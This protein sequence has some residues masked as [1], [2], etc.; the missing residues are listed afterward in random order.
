M[1]VYVDDM[2]VK[3]QTTVDHT[4][5]LR[6][7]FHQVRK[8]NIAEMISPKNLKEVQRLIGRLTSLARF[9]P[10]LT[11]KVR[12]ILKIMKKQTAEK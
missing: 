3:S 8:Y 1:E 12:P 7:V 2:V 11:E 5:N 10:R 6:E 4:H 9:L